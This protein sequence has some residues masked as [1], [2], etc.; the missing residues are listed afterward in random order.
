M[1]KGQCKPF[2]DNCEDLISTTPPTQTFN[3]KHE[4]L[5]QSISH[6][7]QTQTTQLENHNLIAEE[8]KTGSNSGFMVTRSAFLMVTCSSILMVNLFNKWI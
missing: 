8:Q 1:R 3:A 2:I 4:N 5:K 6:I 7:P